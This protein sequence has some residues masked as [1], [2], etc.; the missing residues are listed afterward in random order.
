[1][2]CGRIG[3]IK[4][5]VKLRYEGN[6]SLLPPPLCSFFFGVQTSQNRG[7]QAQAG[8]EET[9]CATMVKATGKRSNAAASTPPVVPERKADPGLHSL[10][11]YGDNLEVILSSTTQP[12]IFLLSHHHR[13]LI[14][15]D[16]AATATAA[17]TAVAVRQSYGHNASVPHGAWRTSLLEKDSLAD[18]LGRIRWGAKLFHILGVSLTLLLHFLSL[19][20][21]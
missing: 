5:S 19:C 7:L 11:D 4:I 10:M 2:L 8:C 16:T 12:F 15:I 9:P 13:L 6:V 21:L 18:S 3:V 17:A 14:P 20:T 1:M